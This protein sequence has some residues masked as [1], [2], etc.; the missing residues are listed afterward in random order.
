MAITV[1]AAYAGTYSKTWN[2]TSSADGDTTSSVSHGFGAAPALYWVVPL[3]S[4][5]AYAKQW[6]ITSVT[7]NV[8]NFAGISAASSGLA[9]TPQVQIV[10]MLPNSLIG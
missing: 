6:A 8:I 4:A 5:N 2:V 9:G 7:A 3:L 1:A 10:A